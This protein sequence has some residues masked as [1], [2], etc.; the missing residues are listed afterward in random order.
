MTDTTPVAM[1]LDQLESALIAHWFQSG[2]S[3]PV[4]ANLKSQVDELR[5]RSSKRVNQQLQILQSFVAALSQAYFTEIITHILKIEPRFIDKTKVKRAEFPDNQI[6]DESAFSK[7]PE[8]QSLEYYLLETIHIVLQLI[9]TNPVSIDSQ[10]ATILFEYIFTKLW[11]HKS[12]RRVYLS[13]QCLRLLSQSH[14]G[15]LCGYII[16]KL[17]APKTTPQQYIFFQ[18]A[19][20]GF[21]FGVETV[22]QKTSTMLYL[23]YQAQILESISETKYRREICISLK[24]I[25]MQILQPGNS[26]KFEIWES[27]CQSEDAINFWKKVEEIYR[28]IFKW[29][30]NLKSS[31]RCVCYELLAM[32]I[33]FGIPSLRDKLGETLFRNIFTQCDLSEICQILTSYFDYLK[34]VDDKQLESAAVSAQ[35]AIISDNLLPKSSSHEPEDT[36]LAF[37]NVGVELGSRNIVLAMKIIQALLVGEY[38]PE[39]KIAALSILTTLAQQFYPEFTKHGFNVKLFDPVYECLYNTS[40][41]VIDRDEQL[42]IRS[43]HVDQ[44]HT[45]L[46]LVHALQCFPHLQVPAEKQISVIDQILFPLSGSLVSEVAEAALYALRDYLLVNPNQYLVHI[47]TQIQNQLNILLSLQD[48]QIQ[49]AFYNLSTLLYYLNQ[50]IGMDFDVT[51]VNASRFCNLRMRIEGILLVWL[52]RQES[53]IHESAWKLLE[54]LSTPQMRELEVGVEAQHLIDHLPR[55]R[56]YTGGNNLLNL[57]PDFSNKFYGSLYCQL[58]WG[59]SVLYEA[60]N[61]AKLLEPST[62]SSQIGPWENYIRFLCL[63]P[64]Q[65]PQNV[66]FEEKSHYLSKGVLTRMFGQLMILLQKNA[67]SNILPILTE[68]LSSLHPS[69]YSLVIQTI[70]DVEDG[71]KSDSSLILSPDDA[72]SDSGSKTPRS[73]TKLA[74]LGKEFKAQ[75]DFSRKSYVLSLFSR[76]L[77]SMSKEVFLDPT[78]EI[79]PHF[80]TIFT[81]WFSRGY[82]QNLTACPIITK[83]DIFLIIQRCIEFCGNISKI[84]PEAVL[85]SHIKFHQQLLFIISFTEKLLPEFQEKSFQ[86]NDDLIAVVCAQVSLITTIVSTEPIEASFE[87]VEQALLKLCGRGAFLADFSEDLFNRYVTMNPSRFRGLVEI[88]ISN[89]PSITEMHSPTG[90]I[91]LCTPMLRALNQVLITNYTQYSNGI[92]VLLFYTSLF[93]QCSFDVVLRSQAVELATTISGFYDDTPEPEPIMTRRKSV[94]PSSRSIINSNSFDTLPQVT[95]TKID[96]VNFLPSVTHI[97]RELYLGIA[98]RYAAEV[99]KKYQGF[100]REALIG[101]LEFT[102]LV[103]QATDKALM[104][105]FA[106]PWAKNY[107][108]IISQPPR[109]VIRALFDITYSYANNAALVDALHQLWEELVSV[110]SSSAVRMAVE[111]LLEHCSTELKKENIDPMAIQAGTL[112]VISILRNAPL[113]VSESITDL[114]ISKLRSYPREIP[115]ETVNQFLNW[116]QTQ[117]STSAKDD[118]FCIE[119]E[120]AAL[121]LLMPLVLS[122]NRFSRSASLHLILH[123]AFVLNDPS[124]KFCGLSISA[125]DFVLN[126]LHCLQ[127]NSNLS[128]QSNDYSKLANLL[129]DYFLNQDLDQ[130]ESSRTKQ[131]SV[132]SIIHIPINKIIRFVNILNTQHASLAN[133]WTREAFNWCLTSTDVSVACN[134]FVLYGHLSENIQHLN[135]IQFTLV[136]LSHL[137]KGDLPTF[138]SYSEQLI[139]MVSRKWYNLNFLG[140]ESLAAISMNLLQSRSQKLFNFGLE[141]CIALFDQRVEYFSKLLPHIEA[142]FPTVENQTPSETI[143]QFLFRGLEREPSEKR[144]LRLLELF[145][146]AYAIAKAPIK[147]PI[148]ITAI[149]THHVLSIQNPDFAIPS[150]NA[151]NS[152]DVNEELIPLAGT[153]QKFHK[154]R[155]REKFLEIFYQEFISVYPEED[156]FNLTLNILKDL[157]RSNQESLRLSAIQAIG[158]FIQLNYIHDLSREQCKT[159][160]NKVLLCCNSLSDGAQE[161]TQSL[162][163]FLL[164]DSRANLPEKPFELLLEPDVLRAD[165]SGSFPS[166]EPEPEDRP[167]AS[168]FESFFG[169]LQKHLQII[170]TLPG[171]EEWN[172]WHLQYSKEL[173]QSEL[174]ARLQEEQNEEQ[175]NANQN[176]LR[177]RKREKLFPESKKKKSADKRKKKSRREKRAGKSGSAKNLPQPLNSVKK[178]PRLTH[179]Q[180]ALDSHLEFLNDDGPEPATPIPVVQVTPVHQSEPAP[181]F[182]LLPD[183]NVLSLKARLNRIKENDAKQREAR[184]S[185]SAPGT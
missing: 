65:A 182:Q 134:S 128:E 40:R 144:T 168:V 98:K 142:S 110:D 114:L 181:Q 164:A 140:F 6:N 124:S 78:Y 1:L 154:K 151:L 45:E 17:K 32:I 71:G 48:E 105:R 59:W 72:L 127:I 74:A 132:Q 94:D 125:D 62:S 85:S 159:I 120:R 116:Y 166:F 141:L 75:S 4:P 173:L 178:S 103:P 27:F 106:R 13:N 158:N 183:E 179:I 64:R 66:T 137:K 7:E 155:S 36:I 21:D 101:L 172:K 162:L 170:S 177:G 145:A 23:S 99:A 157:L 111:W 102:K 184:R 54:Q 156:V 93:F 60:F 113:N 33:G 185:T 87:L 138:K 117:S 115:L 63:I 180:N 67:T 91:G 30:K 96:P 121:L 176:A 81:T 69:C 49:Q 175:M 143:I 50:A 160:T 131:A 18:Q 90:N 139:A 42:L 174:D 11:E 20:R 38:N 8:D 82:Y 58:N 77:R 43:V 109:W 56:R 123:H 161:A 14:L 10:S 97:D 16:N 41:I 5:N 25:F 122:A 112:A 148:T 52:C 152:F 68:C 119:T 70:K 100:T 44:D 26:H 51:G 79:F 61:S 53:W 22:P 107:G 167:D 84:L 47:L 3:I 39:F 9:S 126:L 146:Y 149:L 15:E 73:L 34:F 133:A 92:V 83:R 80:Q 147:N 136:T 12:L 35:W 37:I 163:L 130:K 24:H 150:F 104:L 2:G 55:R 86:W 76:F 108:T 88:C 129:Q 28:A 29:A 31:N 135:L 57:L 118:K 95:L 19:V 89:S 169:F 165:Q 46:I 171:Q 153:F